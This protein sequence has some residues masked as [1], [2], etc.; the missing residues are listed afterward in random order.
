VAYYLGVDIGTGWDDPVVGRA[1]NRALRRAVLHAV[2]VSGSRTRCT[3]A[4][5]GRPTG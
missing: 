1:A 4:A 2:D 5:A 3:A